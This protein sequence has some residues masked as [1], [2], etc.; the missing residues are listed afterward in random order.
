[1]LR[2]LLRYVLIPIITFLL[3]GYAA[4]PLWVPSI[5]TMLLEPNNLQEIELKVGYPN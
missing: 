5:A 4:I 1:M 2:R 3:L